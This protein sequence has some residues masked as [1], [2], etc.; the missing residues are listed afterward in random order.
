MHK[1]EV[2]TATHRKMSAPVTCNKCKRKVDI[3]D[4][5]LCALCNNRYEFDCA[6]YSE[7][8]YRIAKP[9]SKK[10]WKCKNC[11]L[12]YK[13]S[14]STKTPSFVTIRKQMPNRSTDIEL[15]QSTPIGKSSE[16]EDS[17]I[18]TP[19]SKYNDSFTT[20]E[21]VLSRS[22][23]YTKID[24]CVKIQDMRDT[25]NQLTVDLTCTQ[26]ELENTILENNQ[27][28][29]LI[30]KLN[31]ENDLLKHFC[32]SPLKQQQRQNYTSLSAKKSIIHPVQLTSVFSTP[33]P[34][35]T[36]ADFYPPENENHSTLQRRI[37]ELENHLKTAEKEITELTK[38]IHQLEH[39]LLL[40]LSSSTYLG[41]EK[42]T[43]CAQENEKERRSNK[44]LIFGTQQ[45][46]DLAST[47]VHSRQNTKYG[48][49]TVRGEIKS[50]ALSAD[51]LKVCENTIINKNDK[52]ILCIGENDYDLKLLSKQL[53]Y[54][55]FKY[56]DN[57][58]ILLNI[59]KNDYLELR[60]IN[61]CI[62]N[63]CNQYKNCQ[64]AYCKYQSL[65]SMCR[66]IN[67]II[68]NLDYER[69]YLDVKKLNA[70][71]LRGEPVRNDKSS[72]VQ[73][74]QHSDAT[75][76][77]LTAIPSTHKTKNLQKGTILQYFPITHKSNLFRA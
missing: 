36:L 11:L 6:G 4:T 29:R 38:I 58:I 74:Q 51:V 37:I 64:F 73:T 63:I 1:G 42:Y 66:S 49:Y 52:L 15:T 30:N 77:N 13:E 17:Y 2:A 70:L 48:K 41:E 54:V 27:L 12:S 56:R 31:K 32:Q 71:I 76:S 57:D 20:P 67:W 39:R 34:P 22:V 69:K 5:L 3:R 60:K 50:F 45:C 53:K 65:N 14:T 43:N 28:H 7:K 46:I 40:S 19:K 75:S 44:I 33:Q 21:Q 8:L 35:K 61:N 24:D 26:N 55:C 47:L 72:N 16:I 23:D 18:L 59:F 9:D 25:I 10:K 68:D 62:K